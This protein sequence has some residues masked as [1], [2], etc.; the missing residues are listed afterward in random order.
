M[1]KRKKNWRERKT[2]EILA[3]ERYIDA[4]VKRAAMVAWACSLIE[5]RKRFTNDL[6]D[7]TPIF[8]D[9]TFFDGC[10]DGCNGCEKCTDYDEPVKTSS[11]PREI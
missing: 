3:R 2:P 6:R 5:R 4:Q 1:S 10:S 11:S 8:G 9:Y 7:D